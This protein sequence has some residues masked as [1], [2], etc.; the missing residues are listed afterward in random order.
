MSVRPGAALTDHGGKIDRH[1]TGKCHLPVWGEDAVGHKRSSQLGASVLRYFVDG[2]AACTNRSRS[3]TAT[4][5]PWGRAGN[6]AL[7]SSGPP[8]R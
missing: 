7:S 2:V 5:R 1:R 3:S 4:S 8:G 6:G